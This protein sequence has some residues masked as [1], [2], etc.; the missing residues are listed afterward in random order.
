MGNAETFVHRASDMHA[1]KSQNAFTA[2]LRQD[3]DQIRRDV[4][5]VV[6][7]EQSA[8]GRIMSGYTVIYPGCGTRGHAHADREEVYYFIKGSGIMIVDGEETPVTAGDTLYLKPGPFHGTR[9]TT[10]FPF[11]YFWI[12]VKID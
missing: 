8:S 5:V 6:N 2:L 3:G 11:E 7:P 1:E 9:N 4:F 12:T 10:D